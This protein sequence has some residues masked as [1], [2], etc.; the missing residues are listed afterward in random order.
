MRSIIRPIHL[1]LLVMVGAYILLVTNSGGWG[2]DQE[3]RHGGLRTSTR[4]TLCVSFF[5][6]P[7]QI[8]KPVSLVF[9]NVPGQIRSANADQRYNVTICR[10]IPQQMSYPCSHIPTLVQLRALPSALSS[11]IKIS[12]NANNGRDLSL[13]LVSQWLVLHRTDPYKTKN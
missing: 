13:A 4:I 12:S 9:P 8:H 1:C 11:H 5:A 2:L 10:Q 7:R 6:S 3:R